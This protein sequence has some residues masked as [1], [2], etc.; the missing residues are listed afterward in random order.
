MKF[1]LF[2]PILIVIIGY[3][4]ALFLGRVITQGPIV[5]LEGDATANEVLIYF[6]GFLFLVSS[7]IIAALWALIRKFIKNTLEDL[8]KLLSG[9][10]ETLDDI[11]E[12]TAILKDRKEGN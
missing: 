11:K 3:N 8:K 6:I 7:A 2:V 9:V 4:M 12:D 5:M 10:K 1:I